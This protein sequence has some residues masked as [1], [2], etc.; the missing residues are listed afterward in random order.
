MLQGLFWRWAILWVHLQH[1]HHQ[2]HAVVRGMSQIL[3]YMGQIAYDV[4]P[5]KHLWG[6]PLEEIAAGQQVK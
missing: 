4:L 6:I 1:P 5:Q 3:F 2:V